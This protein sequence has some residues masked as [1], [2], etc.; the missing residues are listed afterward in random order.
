MENI[1]I[2]QLA[3]NAM[4]NSEYVDE[5]WEKFSSSLAEKEELFNMELEEFERLDVE[6]Q[7]V[8]QTFF[9]R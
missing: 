4:A 3:L 9:V 2:E 7:N 5:S 6:A 8:A 1:S